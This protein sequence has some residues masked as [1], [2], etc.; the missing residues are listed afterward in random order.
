MFQVFSASGPGGPRPGIPGGGFWAPLA[1]FGV[2]LIGFG[3]LVIIFPRLIGY[4]VGGVLIMVGMGVLGG[5]MN[6]RRMSTV[7][8]RRLDDDETGAGL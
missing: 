1:F 6:M 2:L 8:Y 3:V 5:A 7:S 4:I